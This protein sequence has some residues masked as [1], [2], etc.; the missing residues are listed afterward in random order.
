MSVAEQRAKLTR[1]RDQVDDLKDSVHALYQGAEAGSR[2]EEALEAAL[3][4][5]ASAKVAL[6]RA[7]DAL[8]GGQPS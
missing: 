2:L 4:H 3:S 1:L 8:G 5:L 7:R 6:G